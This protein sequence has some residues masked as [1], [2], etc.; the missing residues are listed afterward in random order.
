[1]GIW[2]ARLGEKCRL[3]KVKKEDACQCDLKEV[4]QNRNYHE[5]YELKMKNEIIMSQKMVRTRK[6]KSR[7]FSSRGFY[8]STEFNYKAS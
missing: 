4:W 8:L 3:A 1:M 7:S 6:F 2:P 5:I